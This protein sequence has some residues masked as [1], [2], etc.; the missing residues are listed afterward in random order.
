MS[1]NQNMIEKPVIYLYPEMTQTV[2]VTLKPVGELQFTYPAYENGWKITATPDGTLTHNGKNYPYLFWDAAMNRDMSS[3]DVSQ[4]FVVEKENTIAF[5]EEQLNIFGFTPQERTDFI[6]YWGPRLASEKRAF[7][8]FVW[9]KATDQFG[10]LNIS[11]QPDNINRVYIQWK[12][13]KDGET[14]PQPTPQIIPVLDRSGF[15]VLEWGG[16]E[17]TNHEL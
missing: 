7:I 3:V 17:L 1:Q 4:G 5:L 13:L 9:G 16:V 15:D 8:Q 2:D 12:S 14:I 11:P 10:Q 6:T